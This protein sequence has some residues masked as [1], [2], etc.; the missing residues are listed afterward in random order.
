MRE[1]ES[2][3]LGP[4]EGL[5]ILQRQQGEGGAGGRRRKGSRGKRGGNGGHRGSEEGTRGHGCEGLVH[6][7]WGMSAVGATRYARGSAGIEGNDNMALLGA[8]RDSGGGCRGAG[9]E[10]GVATRRTREQ[11]QRDSGGMHSKRRDEQ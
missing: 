7:R 10:S 11:P 6:I 2:R 1:R 5:V 9:R 8:G 4:A 3:A